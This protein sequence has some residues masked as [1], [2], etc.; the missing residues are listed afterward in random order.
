MKII[1]SHSLKLSDDILNQMTEEVRDKYE[2][3]LDNHL[4][5][6]R[7]FFPTGYEDNLEIHNTMLAYRDSKIVGYR[8]YFY[9]TDKLDC[10]L[11]N[12][13]VDSNYRR[14]G[15]ATNLLHESISNSIDV[16]IKKFTVR[17]ASANSERQALFNSYK[18][19]AK[20]IAINCKFIIYYD[21]K[22]IIY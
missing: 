8:Y 5:F 1:H 7:D 3:F 13:F 2:V 15:I 6:I 22:E 10:E 12:I 11:F 20:N 18:K 19:I 17:M 9:S 16:G 4:N 21:G 14:Q